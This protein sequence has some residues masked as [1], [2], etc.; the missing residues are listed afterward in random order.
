MKTLRTSFF[1]LMLVSLIKAKILHFLIAAL[2]W[3]QGAL[4]RKQLENYFLD[5]LKQNHE[6]TICTYSQFS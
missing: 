2:A 1:S 6:N 3:T 5:Q 4:R